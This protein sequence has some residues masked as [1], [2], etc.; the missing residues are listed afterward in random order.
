MVK[1]RNICSIDFFIS[2]INVVSNAPI[3]VVPDDFAPQST[4]FLTCIAT[5]Q[6]VSRTILFGISPNG[7]LVNAYGS[8][9][10][11]EAYITGTYII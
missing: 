8:G 2:G 6:D 3:A 4:R 10:V 11:T 9:V 5:Y 7:N 1:T